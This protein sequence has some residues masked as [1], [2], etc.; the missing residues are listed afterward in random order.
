MN[1][2]LQSGTMLP[3][4]DRAFKEDYGVLLFNGNDNV[5]S[6]GVRTAVASRA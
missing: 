5:S 1:E 3:F 2:S 6:S 4:I